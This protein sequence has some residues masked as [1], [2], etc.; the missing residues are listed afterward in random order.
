MVQPEW[1]CTEGTRC[2]VLTLLNPCTVQLRSSTHDESS[3]R[4]ATRP[5]WTGHP[6]GRK[7]KSEPAVEAVNGSSDAAAPEDFTTALM[8]IA[9]LP[10]SDAEKAEASVGR[11]SQNGCVPKA[12][13]FAPSAYATHA[14]FNFDRARTMNHL[15]ASRPA[16]SGR[17]IRRVQRRLSGESESGCVILAGV[18]GFPPARE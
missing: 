11:H 8:M 9:T 6:A 15:V 7:R 10:L 2:R 3:C 4:F 1:L 16:H 18:A 5:F 12:Q 17:A 13:D 14:P